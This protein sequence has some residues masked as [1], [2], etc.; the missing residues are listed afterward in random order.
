MKFDRQ[1]HPR[2]TLT[3]IIFV[4]LVTLFFGFYLQDFKVLK[5][6]TLLRY[7]RAVAASAD[8]EGLGELRLAR[9]LELAIDS[10]EWTINEKIRQRE[11]FIALHG[12]IQKLL[13]KN[14]IP[15]YNYGALYRT[16]YGQITF[17][18]NKAQIEA[19]LEGI[20]KLKSAL[21]QEGLELLY[22]QAP[23]KLPP[24]EQQIPA[25]VREYANDNANRFLEGLKANG[26]DYYDLRPEFFSNGLT[27]NQRFYNTDH[28]WTIEAAFDSTISIAQRLSSDYGVQIHLPRLDPSQF[29][30][31]TFEKFYIGSMGR[32]VGRF[33]AG[34]DDFTVITPGYETQY[35][36][37]EKDGGSE[38]VLQGP[39]E[40]TVLVPG[41]L[42]PHK[43]VD[44][45]RYAAY[46]GDHAELILTNHF[47]DQGRILMIKDS[48]GLPVYAF[49]S[50]GVH[51]IRALDIRL[52]P[53]SVI[54]Y[55]KNFQPDLVVLLY[56]PDS[57]ASSMFEF[58][59]N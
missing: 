12:L 20:L 34:L 19:D 13:G 44:T 54:E 5:Q 55:A 46:H 21:D 45:N 50:L 4:L 49:L 58:S 41:Y 11:G 16:T 31:T 47:E 15:D 43:P 36:V 38:V 37:I 52:Y 3:A 22:I 53:G 18:V 24:H 56:N 57:L 33:Y 29:T 35:T 27:Q 10:A 14:I 9:K 30:F 42:D 2:E 7:Q 28:H 48:F 39:F 26:I 6:E 23:F 51:E 40:E 8:E 17:T 59:G 25:H 32:R 1:Q